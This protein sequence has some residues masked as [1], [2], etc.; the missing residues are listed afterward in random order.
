MD[1]DQPL[2]N[3]EDPQWIALIDP[4]TQ[5]Q[6]NYKQAVINNINKDPREFDTSKPCLVC[7]KSG[8]TFDDCPILNNIAHLKK[9][10]ISWKMFLARTARQQEEINHDNTVN[11][12]ETEYYNIEH[13]P[14]Y[15]EVEEI[16]FI[17]EDDEETENSQETSDFA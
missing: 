12:L 9:H 13:E 1:P 3:L 8:H 2:L 17:E 15:G 14:N 7:N 4:L 11:L 10:Y 16:N 6:D 5:Y